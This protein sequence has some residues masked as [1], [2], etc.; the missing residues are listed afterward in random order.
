MSLD[1]L[2]RMYSDH[3]DNHTKQITD[4]RARKGW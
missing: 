2:L 3:G 1:D 4:L